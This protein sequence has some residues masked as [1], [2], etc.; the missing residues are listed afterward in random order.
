MEAS[1]VPITLAAGHWGFA[2]FV[3]GCLPVPSAFLVGCWG[4]WEGEQWLGLAGEIT[5]ECQA[6]ADTA[7]L[8]E[9]TFPSL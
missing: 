8:P 9:T 5:T 4:L 2:A 3:A 1:A 6:I 7:F